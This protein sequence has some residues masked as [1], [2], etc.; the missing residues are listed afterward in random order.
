L[1]LWKT[2]LDVT[3][4]INIF[5]AG[6]IDESWL[7]QPKGEPSAAK[8]G[9]ILLGFAARLKAAP[10]QGKNAFKNEPFQSKT[11]S[12][13]TPFQKQDSMHCCVTNVSRA[14]ENRCYNRN[15]ST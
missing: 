11:L 7:R 3:L 1:G 15:I 8:A 13:P 2:R 9:V 10:F 14:M 12:K 6:G 4:A 5:L